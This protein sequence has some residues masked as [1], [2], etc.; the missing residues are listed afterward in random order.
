MVLE[1]DDIDDELL[2]AV[3]SGNVDDVTRLLNSRSEEV[4]YNLLLTDFSFNGQDQ[5]TL[6]N[7]AALSRNQ[8]LVRALLEGL[9]L[10]Y[11]KSILMVAA[12]QGNVTM[13]RALLEG[14]CLEERCDAFNWQNG[15]VSTALMCAARNGH[16]AVID[17]L[18]AGLEGLAR[19]A[20]LNQQDSVGVTALM[21]AAENNNLETIAALP[22]GLSD[23]ERLAVLNQRDPEGITALIY[24]SDNGD[25]AV[26]R[27]V[28]NYLPEELVNQLVN[29]EQSFS[30]RSYRAILRELVLS[31]SVIND[32]DEFVA[33]FN[34]I[35]DKLGQ[36]LSLDSEC[37]MVDNI[38]RLTGEYELSDEL[39]REIFSDSA[40]PLTQDDLR[41]GITKHLSPQL[42][43]GIEK[44]IEEV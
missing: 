8:E 21:Y 32:I 13:V 20:A 2:Q 14:L 36:T 39:I 31:F 30:N 42:K 37:P 7:I 3:R 26:V 33:H 10:P 5:Q 25:L 28:L 22:A 1:R 24:A 23:A 4:R 6:L 34:R 11:K 27:A 40:Y 38:N 15:E 44:R 12:S 19:V 41:Q 17:A 16:A 43:D 9:T 29:I 18:L 35:S